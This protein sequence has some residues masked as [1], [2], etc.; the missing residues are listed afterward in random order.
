MVN[1]NSTMSP[2]SFML[3]NMLEIG[4]LQKSIFSYFTLFHM[5]IICYF[6]RSGG[7]EVIFKLPIIHSVITPLKIE[8]VS[9][10]SDISLI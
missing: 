2:L 8:I 1:S 10:Y 7:S 3:C 9:T 6:G 5:H 4:L